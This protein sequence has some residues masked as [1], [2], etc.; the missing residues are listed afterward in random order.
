VTSILAPAGVA[1]VDPDPPPGRERSVAHQVGD[2]ADPHGIVADPEGPVG[3][4]DGEVDAAPAGGRA[5]LL[6]GLLDGRPEVVGAEVQED[7]PGIEL[8]E[9]EQVLGQ[10][11]EAFDLDGARLEELGPGG[12]ILTGV[13][14]EELIEGPDRRDRR[15]QLVRDVGQEVAA[16]VRSRRMM[17]TLSGRDRPW[18]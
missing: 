4:L 18:R 3:Q 15:A 17:S 12:R 11:V 14:L 6:H 1:H 16:P 13:L 2:L 8:R 9:L 7:E 10:P 5:R